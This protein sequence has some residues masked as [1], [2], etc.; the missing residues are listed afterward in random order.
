MHADGEFDERC[1]QV[2]EPI[3]IDRACTLRSRL[4]GLLGKDVASGTLLIEPCSSIHTFGM[5]RPIDVAFVAS[6]G[7]VLAVCRDLDPNRLLS[8]RGAVATFE[9]FAS[10]KPWPEAGDKLRHCVVWERERKER[11]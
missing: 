8:C 9:R 11:L 2:R 10:E 6:D 4:R 5:R 1:V 3:A 7:T